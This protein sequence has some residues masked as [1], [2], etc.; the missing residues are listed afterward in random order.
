MLVAGSE[1]A[2]LLAGSLKALGLGGLLV[3]VLL[4]V[5]AAV[6]VGMGKNLV[7]APLRVFRRRGK[8]EDQWR[9]WCG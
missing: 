3:L 2:V 8:R 7:S 4:G 1:H 9:C 5:V 6:S